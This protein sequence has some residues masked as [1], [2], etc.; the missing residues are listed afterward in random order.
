MCKTRFDSQG[1]ILNVFLKIIRHIKLMAREAPPSSWQMPSKIS[2]FVF[3]LSPKLNWLKAFPKAYW[4]RDL[5]LFVN[6]TAYSTCSAKM[7]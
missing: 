3:E 4:T 7:N 2:I 6:V 1:M 5:S